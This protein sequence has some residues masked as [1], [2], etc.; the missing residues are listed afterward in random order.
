MRLLHGATAVRGPRTA[1]PHRRWPLDPHITP[2][3]APG[4][5]TWL[6]LTNSSGSI[7]AAWHT[8]P[9]R[10]GHGFD[11]S[12][13]FVWLDPG[14]PD[15]RTGPLFGGGLAFVVQGDG[16]GT[17]A[18]GCPHGGLGFRADPDPR[19][20]DCRRRITRGVALA[21]YAN[22]AEIVRTDVDFAAPLRAVYFPYDLR[23]DDGQMHEVRMHFI[24]SSGGSI[25]LYL[26]DMEHVLMHVAP[27]DL[28][29]HALDARGMGLV[30][31]TAASGG[32]GREVMVEVHRWQ[33]ATAEVAQEAHRERWKGGESQ[34][35]QDARMAA[36]DE[37]LGSMGVQRRAQ[38]SGQEL[39]FQQA[40]GRR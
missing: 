26:D 36:Y 18:A 22:H 27:I 8:E 33:L 4:I 2:S 29:T 19:N 25:T 10:L 37:L 14:A 34:E 20:S 24:A 39:I 23:L 38:S 9:L 31:F 1:R 21:L 12:F 40:T 30:G 32:P 3:T 5:A 16:R 17:F 28:P 7:G 13:S 35:E 6:R 11:A 15:G